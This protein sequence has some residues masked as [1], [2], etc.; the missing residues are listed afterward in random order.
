MPTRRAFMSGL[1]AVGLGS[2]LPLS[3]RAESTEP[4]MARIKRTG[5]LRTGF[6]AGAAPYFTKSVATGEWQGFGPDF[7]RALAQALGVQMQPLETTWGNSV[8]DLQSNKIDIMFGLGPTEQRRK[9]IGFSEPLF[10]NTFTLVARKDFDP[11]TWEEADK[12]G[13]KI[14][15]DI[16]SN[17]DAFATATFKNATISRFD[18]SGDATLALQA[19]RVDAQLLVAL[20]G[21][22]VLAKSP[23]LGHMVVPSPVSGSPVCAGFQKETDTAFETFVNQWIAQARQKGEIKKTILANMQQLVG[24]DPASFP[25]EVQ[26]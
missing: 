3:G 22:T 5:V 1:C 9:M 6:V 21:V 4:A 13:I 20:L 17:Q 24:I 10:H 26:L 25:K 18:T 2:V 14:S 8:L 11:K 19:G 23:S 15:V 12:A 7:A 16:G